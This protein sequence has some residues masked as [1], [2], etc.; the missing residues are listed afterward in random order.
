M[1][2]IIKLKCWLLLNSTGW[3]YPVAQNYE[4]A[5]YMAGAFTTLGV[6]LL[7]LVPHLLPLKV[8]EEWRMRSNGFRQRIQSTTSSEAT[9][10]W[11]LDSGSFCSESERELEYCDKKDLSISLINNSLETS[12]VKEQS[13][14]SGIG[15]IME[16]Y[17]S[18]PKLVNQK[19]SLSGPFCDYSILS[20]DVWIHSLDPNRET[21]VWF[22]Y[23]LIIY[24]ILKGTELR[25]EELIIT[26]KATLTKIL[27]LTT[28]HETVKNLAQCR[29]SK[30]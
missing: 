20:N 15:Y 21:N 24:F 12:L 9:K 16:K 18:M 13:S 5:F 6:C 22:S 2:E 8:H 4:P 27:V 29:D 19:D 23:I 1:N 17:F 7:F 28:N 14:G 30:S 26:E 11:T 25:R 3:M 10:S